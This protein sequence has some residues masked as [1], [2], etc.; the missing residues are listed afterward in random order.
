MLAS[1]LK[2]KTANSKEHGLI[3]KR[4]RVIIMDDWMEN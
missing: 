2:E 1:I 4:I 3:E